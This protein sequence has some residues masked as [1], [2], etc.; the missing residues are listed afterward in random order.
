MKRWV[1]LFSLLALLLSL[2]AS[3]VAAERE[4]SVLLNG[5]PI[6]FEDQRPVIEGG[7]TLVPIRAVFAGMG[8]D[9]QY[10]DAT[11]TA[12]VRVGDTTVVVQA[13]NQT[14]YVN[15][16]ERQLDVPAQMVNG[17]ILVPLRFMV[18][19][20][21]GEVDWDDVT[22]TINLGTNDATK[23]AIRARKAQDGLAGT[24]SATAAL[25]GPVN[26]TWTIKG[27]RIDAQNQLYE[28]T[29]EV[30]RLI[31][32]DY[33]LVVRDG[34]AYVRDGFRQWSKLGDLGAALGAAGIPI[35]PTDLMGLVMRLADSYALEGAA[36]SPT[37]SLERAQ[38]VHDELLADWPLTGTSALKGV[39][40]K[41]TLSPSGAPGAAELKLS[42]LF[43]YVENNATKAEEWSLSVQSAWT[44]GKPQI[45]WP[46]DLPK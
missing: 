3:A 30:G 17:R 29:T 36:L 5:R 28:V 7:R 2:S 35:D 43:T 19:A 41:V 31:T 25:V 37:F 42:G 18:E 32:L 39:Q 9:I 14:A 33:L 40:G 11:Q 4:I 8:A 34:V 6:I 22:S 23:A 26:A 13:G 20:M 44:E 16:E 1:T 24:L 15:G 10:D 46:A 21:A 12:T 38:S 27:S 45:T